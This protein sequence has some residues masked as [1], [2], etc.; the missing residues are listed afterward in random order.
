MIYCPYCGAP[1]TTEMFVCKECGYKLKEEPEPE[2]N[3]PEQTPEPVGPAPVEP[4]PVEPAPAEPSARMTKNTRPRA[5]NPH[6]KGVFV[7]V[8]IIIAGMVMMNVPP[9]ETHSDDSLYALVAITMIN[10]QNESLDAVTTDGTTKYLSHDGL[11]S[12]YYWASLNYCIVDLD[13]KSQTVTFTATGT[14][15]TGQKY[16]DSTTLTLQ[17]GEEYKIILVL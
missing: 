10:G 16:T 4:E 3:V 15:S 1:I 17:A 2:E 14:S 5:K 11:E 12:G 6:L 13:G 8:L 7:A 9:T